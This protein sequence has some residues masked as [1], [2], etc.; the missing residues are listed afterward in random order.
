MR[1]EAGASERGEET[2]SR[3]EPA[4]GAAGVRDR[5]KQLWGVGRVGPVV[6]S[7]WRGW[8]IRAVGEVWLG[9]VVPSESNSHRSRHAVGRY[10]HGVTFN[11]R[12]RLHELLVGTCNGPPRQ[13]FAVARLQAICMIEADDRLVAVNFSDLYSGPE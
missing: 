9:D 2:R 5:C 11:L 12:G 3:K 7:E 10:H 4:G 13:I 8:Q 1:S 6:G